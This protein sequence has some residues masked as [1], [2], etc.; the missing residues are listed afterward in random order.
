MSSE[1]RYSASVVGCGTGGRLSLQAL[2]S[3]DRFALRAVAD[4]R[5]EARVS[6]RRDFPEVEIYPS[7][8]DL[9]R[10]RPTDI[11]CV[12]TYAPSHLE[13][14]RDALRMVSPK[15]MLVE[16]PVADNMADGEEIARL[17]SGA[18]IP[19]VVPHGLLVAAH[20]DQIL[21]LVRGG[22]I[23]RL[24]LVEIQ[25]EKWDII[26]AGIHWFSFFVALTQGDPV[27]S[28]Q[29]ACDTSTGTYRDG[30]QVETESI[31]YVETSAGVRAVL[32][33]G[34][35]VRT[36][37]AGKGTY[38]RLVGE[39]GEIEFYGWESAYRIRNRDAPAGRLVPVEPFARSN[40]RIHL[41]NLA[42]M[43]DEDRPDGSA[44]R[45]SLS[46]LEICLAA[47][48]SHRERCKVTLPLAGFAP[49]RFE[50][51]DPGVP[52]R[53]SGGGRNGRLLPEERLS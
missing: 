47:Y 12:S 2:S 20:G 15:G 36:I 8:Q 14:T 53:G 35:D 34:D 32:Q 42:R 3:S 50:G 33:T 30:M 39:E 13:I 51:W 11:V 46:A 1:R 37:R 5:P 17:L 26:N 23:G 43:V 38:F 22:A 28:V 9:F 21:G 31:T 45:G 16:K 48:A 7:H 27:R 29:S 24:E 40:H 49:R 19:A 41:E 52:Y 44:L 25:C 10:E 6:V 4:V 18:G